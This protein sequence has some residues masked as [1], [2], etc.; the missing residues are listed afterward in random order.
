MRTAL[1]LLLSALGALA[2]NVAIA[3]LLSRPEHE[4]NAV[5][6]CPTNWPVIVDR[7]GTNA[8]SPFPGRSIITEDQ[9]AALYQSIGPTFTN[10]HR[11]AWANY[12]ATNSAA[13]EGRRSQLI[14]E[15]EAL[16]SNIRRATNT[17]DFVNASLAVSNLFRLRQLEERLGN[18]R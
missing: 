5:A 16:L 9:L 11:T 4:F 15:Q 13:I 14:A 18:L 12:V 17:A 3:P 8:A 6:G 1:L 10:W 2:Q 7:L